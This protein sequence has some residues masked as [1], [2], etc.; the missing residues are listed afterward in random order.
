M[1]RD[2]G[3]SDCCRPSRTESRDGRNWRFAP[4]VLCC[5]RRIGR[6][7]SRR[8]FSELDTQ[9]G[10]SH[11][12]TRRLLSPLSGPDD[13]PS[14]RAPAWQSRPAKLESSFPRRTRV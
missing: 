1:N 6:L 14:A 11:S 8:L 2:G 12:L 3:G 9:G 4:L 7:I 10:G 13:L 5:V